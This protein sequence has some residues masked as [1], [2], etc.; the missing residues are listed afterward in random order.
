MARVM[1]CSSR[2]YAIYMTVMLQ[3]HSR[4][5][6]SL[7]LALKKEAAMKDWVNLHHVGSSSLTRD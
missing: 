4:V 6:L 5:S 2:C 7:L 1:R 3:T